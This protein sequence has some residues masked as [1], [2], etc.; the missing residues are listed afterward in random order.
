[1]KKSITKETVQIGDRE[2]LL[3]TYTLPWINFD[4]C[5]IPVPGSG[6][7]RFYFSDEATFQDVR[8][9]FRSL[10]E[11]VLVKMY[12]HTPFKTELFFEGGLKFSNS[13]L[14]ACWCIVHFVEE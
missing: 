14:S 2:F 7:M 8:A 5:K 1:M 3:D 13:N 11:V 12:R 4:K 10:D 9:F 6:H